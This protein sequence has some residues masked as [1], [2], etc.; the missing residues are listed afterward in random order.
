MA[1]RQNRK[2]ERGAP[3]AV[4]G[5]TPPTPELDTSRDGSSPMKNSSGGGSTMGVVITEAAFLRPP[6]PSF[7]ESPFGQRYISTKPKAIVSGDVEARLSVWLFNVRGYQELG[8]Y[9]ATSVRGITD[10]ATLLEDWYVL[11]RDMAKRALKYKH[12]PVTVTDTEMLMYICDAY[13]YVLANLTTLLN[14]NRLPQYN[15][16]FSVLAANLPAYMARITRLWRR[17]SAMAMPPWLK[18]HAIRNGQIVHAPGVLAPTLRLWSPYALLSAGSGGPTVTALNYTASTIL[19]S[20]TY[21]GTFVSNL[22]AVE[23]W[24]ETGTST[25]ITDFVAVKDLI[26]MT[27]DICPQAFAS[28]LP[29]PED[30]PGL[31]I[32]LGVITDLTRRACFRKDDVSAGTDRWTIFPVPGCAEFGSRIPVIGLGSPSMYDH[33]LLGAP[34]YGLL[35]NT[36]LGVKSADVDSDGMLVGT[37]YWVGNTMDVAQTDISD[38]FGVAADEEVVYAPSGTV[39]SLGEGFRDE[40]TAATIRTS[41]LKDSLK[42]LHVWDNIRFCD[43]SAWPSGWARILDESSYSYI[44]FQEAE[45]LGENYAEFLARSLGV[46][47]IR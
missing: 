14:L 29:K 24:L 7:L 25:V 40:N 37:D 12:L 36:P 30:A 18:E 6:G 2:S 16:A 23:K 13:Y 43:R 46:P 33:I 1:N 11:V 22:E 35:T 4:A 39:A 31:S 8:S 26:D 28:G 42:G 41:V 3:G 5:K 47:Y 45:D 10:G 27:V 32:D 38:V 19:K 20:A 9:T 15:S 21:L 34:K 17:M 44:M